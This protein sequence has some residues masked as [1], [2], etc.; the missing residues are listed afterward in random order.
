MASHSVPP[1]ITSSVRNSVAD[2]FRGVR[3][4]WKPVSKFM[5]DE[6]AFRSVGSPGSSGSVSRSIRA[7]GIASLLA[8]SLFLVPPSAFATRDDVVRLNNEGVNALKTN[9]Y[10]LAIQK[11]EAALK[12]DQTYKLARENLAIAYNNYGIAQQGNPNSAIQQFHKSLFWSPENPTAVQNLDVTI[13][14]L[15]KDPKNFKD[16]IALG[17]QARQSSDFEGAAVEFQE[18]LKIKDDP[19]LRVD[20]G[21]VLRVKDQ[22]DAAIGQYKLASSNPNLDVDGKIKAFR[23]LGQSY[24]AK[25]DFPNSVAAY[26]QAITLDPG[27]RETLEAN[28]AVWSEAVSKDPTSGANHVGLAQAFMYLGDFGQATAEL[29]MALNFNKNDPAALKLLSSMDAAKKFFERDK[30][31]NQGV[32]LQSRQL[33]DPAIQEY[34]A[35]LA[36][37]P[38]NPSILL[39]LG[40]VYQAKNDYKTALDFY[41]KVLALDPGNKAAAEGQKNAKERLSAKQLDDAVAE[42]S[43]LFKAGKYDEALQRYQYVL[44][45]NPSDAAAHFNV[46]A[47]LQAL[48]RIDEAIA[49]YKQAVSLNPKQASYQEFLT[50]AIQDKADPIIDQAVKKHAEKDYT[51]AISLYQQALAIIPDNPKVLFNLAGAYYSRQQFPEA[52]K[53]YEQLYQKDPKG[54]IDDLW[55]IG[56]I[57]EHNSRGNDAIATY[58]KYLTEAPTGKYNSAAKERLAALR[59]DPS[60]TIKIKSESDIAKDKE[61]DDAYK[62][63]VQLQQQKEYDGALASYQKAMSIRPKDPSIP[64]AIGTLFQAKK[65]YDTALKWFQM[66]IDL[67]SADSKFDKK[68]IDEFRAATKQVREQK[69]A[70]ILEEAVKKQSNGDQ[71]GAIEL[72]KQALQFTDGTGGIWFNMGQ[73]YQLTDDFTNARQAYQ[74]AVDLDPKGQT[75]VWYLIGKIDENFGQGNDAVGHYRKYL[76]AQPT[77]QYATDANQRLAA[78]AKNITATQKLPTQNEMK[79]AKVADEEYAAGLALQKGGN[80]A[81][82]IGHYQK[83]ASVKPDEPAYQEAIATCYQQMKQYDQALAAYDQ[84]IA[85]SKKAGKAKDADLYQQ[86]RDNAAEEKAGPIVDQAL[87]AFQAGDFAKAADLYGQVIQMVPKIAKMHT[88]RAAALQAGDD[89]KNALDEYQKAFDLDPKGEKENLYFIA[90][91]NDHFGRG[92]QALPLYRKYLL[93]NPSGPYV[94]Q[95]RSRADALSKD[96]TK[97]VKIPTSGERKNEEQISGL[98]SEAVA[99]YN[100]GDYDGSITKMQ[101]V[102]GLGQDPVYYYQLGAAYLGAKKFDEAKAALQEAV[103]RDPSNK[104][105][106]DALSAITQQQVGPLVDEGIKK[107]TAGDL[108]GA[109]AAYK[110]ALQ[111]DPNAANVHTNLAS[112]LQGVEDFAGARDE[113][114]KALTLDRKG[115]IGNL[116]FIAALDEN[117]SKGAQALQEYTQYVRE[118]GAGGAYT[119]LAQARIKALTA[120]PNA[121]QKIVTQA[122]QSAA[123]ATSQAYQDGVALQEKGQLDEAIAK[124]QEA[125]KGNPKEPAFVFAIAT[126]YHAKNDFDNAIKNYEIA[127]SLNPKEAQWKTY[128][129]QAKTAKA[130]PILN[131]AI[132]KQ[133]TKDASGN[134]DVAGAIISYEQAL[135]IDDDATTHLN[136]GTAYQNLNNFPRA[137]E[138]YKRALQMDPNQVDAYYY[139]GT[140]YEQMNQP[141]L[142][143]PEYQNYL[144]KQPAGPNAA[145]CKDRLKILGVK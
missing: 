107:Q 125:I 14:N 100:K 65:D 82:A 75:T 67:G 77:G 43:N 69:A 71:A 106:K 132:T 57:Q 54:Q 50:K 117:F 13:Q 137:L 139:M 142:A 40:S 12:I 134:Y 15:G 47:T 96:V 128:L 123:Q 122:E 144:R 19:K 143:I 108:Q 111:V 10:Q 60:D 95:A 59:R 76:L 48:K 92:T 42:G 16:R 116:Y 1:S 41:A 83:A 51:T 26:N 21:D 27:D 114:Q 131:E 73:A 31:I 110:A 38:R 46:G 140:L 102:L 70:P 133:T 25:G 45:S 127:V 37:D 118:A 145:A 32:D 56:T 120:N 62:A 135:K 72:Y 18:A 24:Q 28:R 99:L 86:Q 8:L 93:E 11:F 29:R 34:N 88:S 2:L 130:A 66:A 98:Y 3:Q 124:Y 85:L 90:A 4:L 36:V 74:K 20:L 121:V 113:F 78:L 141:K 5:P 81:E 63:G 30:H 112:V 44:R 7:G 64:F 103:K 39:N 9:N 61:A 68:T 109:I 104:T 22:L 84:A 79:T 53:I 119:G 105:Y 129:K 6:N 97:T 94:T 138:N 136:L 89:F 55:L 87:A 126:A 58:T 23:S 35:A 49:E 80:P 115:Q 101:A 33:Y 17:K 52:Q 91:L